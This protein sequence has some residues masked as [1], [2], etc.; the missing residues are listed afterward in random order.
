MKFGLNT[1]NK[2]VCDKITLIFLKRVKLLKKCCDLVTLVISICG[3]I[4]AYQ[5]PFRDCQM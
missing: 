3:E 1:K 4:P 5:G 2:N